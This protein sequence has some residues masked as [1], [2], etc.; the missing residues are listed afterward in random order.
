[1][2][3]H[4]V[5]VPFEESWPHIARYLRVNSAGSVEW[6]FCDWSRWGRDGLSSAE[7]ATAYDEWADFFEW[8]PAQRA[9]KLVGNPRRR[10]QV[11]VWTDNMAYGCRQSAAAARGEDPGRWVPL[12]ERRPDLDA[13]GRA[14][15]EEILARSDAETGHVANRQL[16][17]TAV[18]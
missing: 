18:A 8:R 16:V 1:V 14:I 4:L 15:V 17:R 5:E 7:L 2:N 3:A 9:G 11:E 10:H 13:T 12:W 6:D